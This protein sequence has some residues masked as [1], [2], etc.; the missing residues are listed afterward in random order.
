MNFSQQ[1]IPTHKPRWLRRPLP[2]GPEYE[3]M[4]RLI[5]DHRLVTVCQQARC[6]NQFECFSRGTAT[7]MILGDRCSRSC[8]FCAVATGNPEPPDR[9]EPQRVARAV[10]MLKLKYAVV[11]SVTRDDLADG[12][13]AHFAATI[14]AV[15]QRCPQTR[16]EVLIPDMQG[17]RDDLATILAAA[18]DILN[19][20]IETVPSLYPSV[21][22]QAIYRRSLELFVAAQQIAP[23]IPCKSGIMLGLGERREELLRAFADLRAAGC[24]ILTL[25]QY[26]QPSQKHRAVSRFVPPEEFEELRR[27]AL[28]EGFAA[29]ISGPMVRSSYS[30][31]DVYTAMKKARR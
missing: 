14:S 10:E 4:R 7:F 31:G 2:D 1:K 6:P 11:T 21:R 20:N 15:H 13:A 24:S 27:I 22:P 18:P 26:L 25:G 19:H 9:D 12:G 28:A 8:R 30:A 16:I 3:K 29:V 5:R 23:D 17:N